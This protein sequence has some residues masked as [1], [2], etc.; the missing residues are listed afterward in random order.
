M[1]RVSS[2]LI[3]IGITILVLG[4]LPFL[5]LVRVFDRD[6]V[7][8]RTGKCFRR[9]GL[10]ISRVNPNWKVNVEGHLNVDDRAPY[11]M[12]CNHQSNADIPVVSNLPWEMKWVAKKELFKIPVLGLMMK[13]S[14]D[15]PVDRRNDGNKVGAFK[16]SV[17]YLQNRCS[18]MFFP[19]GTR[20]RDGKV[21]KFSRGAFELAIKEQIPILPLVLDGTRDCLPKDTWVF[22]PDVHVRLKVL[23][24]VSVTG[25]GPGDAA[26]LADEVRDRMIAQLAR[27][28]GVD[29]NEV[30][31]TIR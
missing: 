9:L 27:W 21:R 18:L 11:V 8:Y 23:E 14:G 13:L 10:A 17:F 6:P 1:R 7:R 5:C 19:E 28:R 31:G 30:D 25:Y 29:R 26:K 20:S 4:W 22:K 3:W 15:I 2:L 16:R 12:V 24:P